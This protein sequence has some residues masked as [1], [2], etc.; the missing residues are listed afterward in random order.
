MPG[1]QLIEQ[2]QQPRCVFAIQHMAHENY[3]GFSQVIFNDRPRIVRKSRTKIV[4]SNAQIEAVLPLD[5]TLCVSQRRYQTR[6]DVYKSYF[7]QYS[8][9]MLS[10]Q[11][12]T[13]S[14]EQIE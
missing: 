4:G 13:K 7:H 8:S 6:S 10:G 11:R 9:I 2:R 14:H 12:S 3:I 1:S 5:L